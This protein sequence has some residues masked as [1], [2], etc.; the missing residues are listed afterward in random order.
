M[1][2]KSLILSKTANM[3]F[4]SNINALF[5]E[6]AVVLQSVFDSLVVVKSLINMPVKERYTERVV[7]CF[8][9]GKFTSYVSS[10]VTYVEYSIYDEI[11]N[12]DMLIC[13]WRLLMLSFC[14]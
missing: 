5:P 1:F 13:K 9:T 8:A 10:W 7:M 4:W 6:M 3:A 14:N 12:Q 2:I 11:K